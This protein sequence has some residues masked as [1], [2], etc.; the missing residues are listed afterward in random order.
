MSTVFDIHEHLPRFWLGNLNAR[1][2][3]KGIFG[4]SV[5]KFCLHDKTSTNCLRLIDFAGVEIWF[6]VVL[7]LAVFR[8]FF[9]YHIGHKDF[10]TAICSYKN[11]SGNLVTNRSRAY[12]FKLLNGSES[13]TSNDGYSKM[14]DDYDV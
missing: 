6:S 12:F 8:S 14:L 13:A 3:N 11:K 5:R 1:V 4:K 2:G 9:L 7:S 10:N